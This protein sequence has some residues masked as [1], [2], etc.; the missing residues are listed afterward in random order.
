MMDV[1]HGALGGSRPVAGRPGKALSDMSGAGSASGVVTPIDVVIVGD[2]SGLAPPDAWPPSLRVERF[3]DRETALRRLSSN[4]GAAVVAVHRPPHL[5]ALDLFASLT[6]RQETLLVLIADIDQ[7]L[8]VEALERV[9]IWR[10]FSH[11]S[12]RRDLP[13]ML[14]AELKRRGGSHATQSHVYDQVRLLYDFVLELPRL[15]SLTDLVHCVVETTA[16]VLDSRRV[17]LMLPDDKGERLRVAASIGI[18]EELARRIEAPVGIPIAGEVF[19]KKTSVVINDLDQL[20]DAWERVVHD[21]EHLVPMV[22]VCLV[23]ADGRA[24]GV[25]NVTSPRSVHRYDQLS[26]LT[27]RAIADAAAIAIENQLHRKQR[28]D[29]RDSLIIAL[30]RLAECRDPETGSHLQRL[31]I[32]C[33]LLAQ[34]LARTPRHQ[35]VIDAAFIE[36]LV[37]SSPLHDIGKVGIDDRILKKPGKHTPEET[38][39][40][41]RHTIIGGDTLKSLVDQGEHHGFLR[42]GME[43]AYCHHEKWDGTGYPNHLKGEEIPLC[44]RILALA[45]VYDALSVRRVYKQPMPHEKV[46]EMIA[47][48]A[49][50]HF[51]PDVVAAFLEAE[52]SFATTAELLADD[53]A[54][55]ADMTVGDVEFEHE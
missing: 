55:V 34:A 24:V 39:A 47:Q 52:Q 12:A 38:Q 29:A 49:G 13:A 46:R 6:S 5:D 2:A 7:S 15:H 41:R 51:D 45:D 35:A 1:S 36:D 27:A 26:L 19:D 22:C 42:M 44:A 10:I 43:I 53:K 20:P 18:P 37:R 16:K 28:D 31:Q 54:E 21:L 23:G 25:L 11:E 50:R 33:R 3:A 14:E 32:Y 48:G 40:M 4:P 9:P 17:S 30:S 8:P